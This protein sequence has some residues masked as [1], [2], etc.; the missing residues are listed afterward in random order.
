MPDKIR[1][2]P[3]ILGNVKL[4]LKTHNDIK[5]PESIITVSIIGI[6]QETSLNFRL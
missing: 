2:I 1:H 5:I 6:L 4:S 3:I